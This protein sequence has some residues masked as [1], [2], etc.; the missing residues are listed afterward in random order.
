MNKD[1]MPKSV[2]VKKK[3]I[4]TTYGYSA[5]EKYIRADLCA[6]THKKE[7]YT[8]EHIDKVLQEIVTMQRENYGDGMA[9]HIKLKALCD[10]AEMYL[11]VKRSEVFYTGEQWG[12]EN[13]KK[14][15]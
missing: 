5:T 12:D 9:T 8:Q 6:I 1:K 3:Y 15:L 4:G 11:S 7:L 13:E 14:I 10:R 2:L